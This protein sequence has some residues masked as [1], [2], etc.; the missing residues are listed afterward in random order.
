[1]NLKF[2]PLTYFRSLKSDRPA[3]LINLI[4]GYSTYLENNKINQRTLINYIG[5]LKKFYQFIG[6]IEVKKISDE[7][8]NKEFISHLRELQGLSLSTAMMTLQHLRYFF[9][10]LEN[11]NIESLNSDKI[12][13]K[14]INNTI[15]KEHRT[16]Y[17]RD[18]LEDEELEA[19]LNYWRNSEHGV[20]PRMMR[21]QLIIQILADTGMTVHEMTLL[22][23]DN[24]DLKKGTINIQYKNS[25]Y[26]YKNRELDLPRATLGL[27]EKYFDLRKDRCQCLVVAFKPQNEFIVEAWPLT[28]RSIQRI[29]VDTLKNVGI[30]K[31]ITPSVFRNTKFLDLYKREVRVSEIKR[32]MGINPSS[33]SYFRY[34]RNYKHKNYRYNLPFKESND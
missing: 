19:L 3:G 23:R 13:D 25:K 7:M 5:S 34:I 22:F 9:Q 32:L 21:N 11:I 30:N 10:Y 24:V 15:L 8:I 33:T 20:N 4:K 28:E 16:S 6:D 17:H 18:F 31:K 1:M 12:I 29:V 14:K 26:Y 27:L 2:S